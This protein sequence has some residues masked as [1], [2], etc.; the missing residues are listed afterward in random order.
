MIKEIQNAFFFCLRNVVSS[1]TCILKII[2]FRFRI[3]IEASRAPI[4]NK[5]YTCKRFVNPENWVTRPRIVDGRQVYRRF[6]CI[7]Y[8]MQIWLFICPVTSAIFAFLFVRICVSMHIQY[9]V[10]LYI[11]YNTCNILIIIIFMRKN[12]N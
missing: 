6:L 11:S 9:S 2:F 8:N 3:H 1:N 10:D 12:L 5:Y 4:H 7:V